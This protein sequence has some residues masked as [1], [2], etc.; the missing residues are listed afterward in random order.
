M[1]SV[2]IDSLSNS[3]DHQSND[4]FNSLSL[5]IKK[6]GHELDEIRTR[7]L[8]NI[9]SKLES[10]LISEDDL[11]QHKQLFIKL[12]DL[13]NFDEFNQYEKVLDLLIQL[14]SKTK[15]ACRNIVDINGIQFLNSLKNENLDNQKIRLKIEQLIDLVMDGSSLDSSKILTSTISHANSF[16]SNDLSLHLKQLQSQMESYESSSQYQSSARSQTKFN[17][18]KNLSQLSSNNTLTEQSLAKNKLILNMDSDK[19]SQN[20][21]HSS[22]FSARSRVNQHSFSINSNDISLNTKNAFQKHQDPSCLDKSTFYWLPLTLMD[23]QFLK[24]AEK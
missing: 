1:E 8:D 16:N 7:S 18:S 6:I 23:I 14:A 22:V 12:F 17:T 15:L 9:I 19:A 4:Q 5:I 3:T 2:V 20:L 11:S 13:F 21:T 24:T 10:N